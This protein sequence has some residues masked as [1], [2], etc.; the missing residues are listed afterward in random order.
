M[1]CFRSTRTHISNS[2]K[3][4]DK[5]TDSK[6]IVKAAKKSLKKEGELK[7]SDLA[8]R[9]VEKLKQTVDVAQVQAELEKSSKVEIRN[10]VVSLKRKKDGD[11][12]TEKASKKSKKEKADTSSSKTT[13]ATSTV[14]EWRKEQK[15]VIMH[16]TDDEEGQKLTG[17]LNK[18]EAYFPFRTFDTPLCQSSMHSALLRQCTEGNGFERP[19]PIQAQAWPILTQKVNGRR[20]DM[21][22]IAETGSG[23]TLAFAMPALSALAQSK[24]SKQKKP[25]MLVLAPTRELAMQSDEVIR[26]FGAVVGLKSLVVYGG[27]PKH[28]QTSELK[29]G[30]DCVVATPG[31]LKDLMQEGSCQLSDI[32]YLVLDEADRMLDMGFEEEVRRIVEECRSKEDGRQTA[33]FSA[34]WPAA[35]QR[36]AMEY[37]VEPVR[38]Y[39]GFESLVGSND[40]TGMIDDSVSANKRVTQHV[41]V[42]EDRQREARLRQLLQKVHGKRNN[43]VLVFALYKKEAERL[44]H[45]L[46]RDGWNCCSIHGNKNQHDRTTALSEFKDGSCP[47]LIATDVAARG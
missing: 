15:V 6:A 4:Q 22:G 2:S 8:S 36:I 1:P 45:S 20:R 32:E 13:A 43:R 25:R 23:K 12:E 30:V 16:G 42:V 28:K 44:E 47:L 9:V 3:T 40:G 5:M 10:G 38:V 31:R 34:T 41:E 14:D 27:V 18:T 24:T 35:I 46:R 39:V 11:N 33:M 37:M 26:E 7:L 29:R 19:S 21:V 17:L